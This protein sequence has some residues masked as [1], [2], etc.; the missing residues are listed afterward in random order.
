MFRLIDAARHAVGSVM[1]ESGMGVAESPYRVIAEFDGARVRSYQER[2]EGGGPILLIIPAPFKKPYIWDLMPSVSVVRHCRS[3]E[4]QVYLLEWTIPGTEQDC[5]GLADYADRLVTAASSAIEEELGCSATV[6]AG[7]SLG[8]TFA[9][10]FAGLHPERVRSLVLVDAPIDFGQE[11]DRIARMV[12]AMPHA[13][14]FRI[15]FGSPVP[16][17]AIN[18]LSASTAPDIFLGQPA[19]DLAASLLDSEALAIHMRVVRWMLDEFP[20][21]GQ[22]FEDIIELLYREN[23]FMDGSLQIG[24]RSVGVECLKSPVLTV[25]NPR[26]V[27]VPLASVQAALHGRSQPSSCALT[28]EG[29]CGPALQHVGP[30]VGPGAHKHLWP[31]ICAW[32]ARCG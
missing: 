5:L 18:L 10:I 1:D 8:G 6:V 27:V 11:G 21:P 19:A 31:K 22:L 16:G 15:I 13:R 29:D 23:R 32:L 25:V 24:G 28:Y 26:G 12:A 7:N 4:L 14:A 20:L 17:S 2:C 3:H 9:A 30:L